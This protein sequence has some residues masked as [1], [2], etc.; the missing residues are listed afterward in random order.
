MSAYFCWWNTNILSKCVNNFKALINRSAWKKIDK[1][2]KTEKW[3]NYGF[4]W[5]SSGIQLPEGFKYGKN[6]KSRHDINYHNNIT[7][8]TF[9][10]HHIWFLMYGSFWSKFH[11]IIVLAPHKIWSFLLTILLLD[12]KK[13]HR[14]LGIFSHLLKKSLTENFIFGQ[15]LLSDLSPKFR[16]FDKLLSRFS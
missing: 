15:S 5:Y 6:W 13:I 8:G 4:A 3:V 16:I 10:R 11:V 7:V 12:V 1:N 9:Q 2:L 14:F